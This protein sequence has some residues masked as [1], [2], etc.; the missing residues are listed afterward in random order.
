MKSLGLKKE[1]ENIKLLKEFFQGEL[2]AY[3][4]KTKRYRNTNPAPEGGIM[5]N[6]PK[7][8]EPWQGVFKNER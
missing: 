2:T 3:V 7:D 4:S 8:F 5:D 1:K 6:D